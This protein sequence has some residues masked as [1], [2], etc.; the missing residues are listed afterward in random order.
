M[1]LEELKAKLD[2]PVPAWKEVYYWFYRLWHNDI[3]YFHKEVKWFFQRARRG[4]SDSDNWGAYH[5]LGRIIPEMLE[6]LADNT[7][8]YPPQ[9]ENLEN[10]Q[11]KLRITAIKI[12]AYNQA[13]EAEPWLGF[14][15]EQEAYEIT[16]EG[17]RDLAE[18]F[19]NLWD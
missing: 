16:Q 1:N 17:I 6:D 15:S 4:W 11:E 2:E 10:W 9:F 8:G 19:G 18:I 13:A 14:E 5:Y 12:R 7:H 3:R